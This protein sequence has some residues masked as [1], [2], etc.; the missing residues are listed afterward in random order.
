V[1]GAAG[2]GDR[3]AGGTSDPGRTNPWFSSSVARGQAYDQ[4][5]AHLAAAGV[6]VHGEASLVASLGVRSV[7]DAG[8]GTGRVAIELARRGLEV[9]GVDIDLVMLDVARSKAPEQQWVRGDLA[10]ITLGRHFD[11]VVMAGNV[12]IFL[13]PGSEAAVLQNMA[14]HLVEGGLLV[15]GFSLRPESLDLAAYDRLAAAAGMTLHE[16]FST[17]ERSPFDSRSDYAVS[18]HRRTGGA[19]RTCSAAEDVDELAAP[20]GTEFDDPIRQGEQRVVSATAHVHPGVDARSALAHD[21][22][23]GRDARP[24]E[25]LDTQSLGLRVPPVAGGAAALGLRHLDPPGVQPAPVMEVISTV[26]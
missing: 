11:A 5:F 13:S 21:D 1:S 3:A 8:C 14:G 15:A 18:I 16:R 7:L 24:V 20:A 26:V 17:W 6:D 9:A 25:H 19:R 4:R 12:M 22:G 2:P 10:T 23:A